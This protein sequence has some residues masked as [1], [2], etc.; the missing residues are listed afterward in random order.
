MLIILT[1]GLPFYLVRWV[2]AD[3]I[4]CNATHGKIEEAFGIVG[5]LYMEHKRCTKP[6][7]GD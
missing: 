4:Q 6:S 2:L 7:I 5:V 3:K 1:F